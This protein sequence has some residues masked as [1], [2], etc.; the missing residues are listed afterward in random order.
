MKD[1]IKKIGSKFDNSFVKTYLVL[2]T[3]LFLI[4]IIFKIISKTPV[5]DFSTL[6]IFI[7]LNVVCSLVSFILNFFGKVV[8]RIVTIL[9][10][11][12]FGIYACLQL[13]FFNFLGVYIS[14]QTS[15]QLGA[16]TDYI[17][18]FLKTFK[19]YYLFELLPFVLLVAYYIFFDKKKVKNIKVN[20]AAVTSMIL[21]LVSSLIY[22]G[23]L[24]IKIFQ[25]KYQ[26]I[27][28]K[29]L[30]LTV[31]NP[32]V[33]IT[34]FGD[35]AFCLL[36]VR[37]M[38]FP[39]VIEEKYEVKKEDEVNVADEYKRKINDTY[40]KALNDE[41]TDETNKNLNEYFMNR[42]ITK[43]NDMTGLFKGKNLVLIMMESVNEIIYEYPELYPNFAKMAG[44]GWYFE[45]NYSPRNSC[46]T[47]NNEFSGMT[48]L[49][50]IYNTCTA[51]KW[52]SN[53]Y[54]E[55]IFGVFNDADYI[56]FSGHDYTD[57]YYPRRTIH[58]NM[59]SGDYY[60]VNRLG[61]S[62]SGEYKN[63]AD[64]ADFA[65]AMLKILD[66]KTEGNDK[67]FMM[68]MTSVS[69]HQPY[70][71]DS[72]TGNKYYSI[73]KNVK[74]LATD[75]RR[76]MSKLKYVDNMLGVMMEGL[77]ERG[78]LEDTVFVLYGDH[79]PYAISTDHLNKA[80]SYNTKSYKNNEKTPLVIYSPGI[81]SKVFSGYTTYL[82][83]VP[84]VANLFDLDYDPRYYLGDDV[85]S[86]DY[87]SLAVFADGSW[88]NETAFYSA[89]KNNI[90]YFSS[91][92]YSAEEIQAINNDIQQKIKISEKAIKNNYFNYLTNGI[93]KKKEEL[94][95][96]CLTEEKEQY[97]AEAK[98]EGENK[99]EEWC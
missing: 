63:W 95:I 92:E 17:A 14:F 57:A 34:Q 94:D 26:T 7:G 85:F 40:W 78:M 90:N 49:Y 36:D 52:K 82:N 71:V 58:P 80:L 99:N 1:F 13:G 91:D 38:L 23:T 56:T 54:G 19:W 35:L 72:I 28:N 21:L 27:S 53:K 65:K 67:N 89:S 3:G 76:Y 44:E 88:K 96:L 86:E 50:S 93:N 4:E 16:V 24:T 70:S 41:T 87:K 79:Y 64:D 39:V 9:L 37:E 31:E 77:Q 6:R 10:V 75:V 33:A 73:S 61:I 12:G 74:G 69:S 62:W 42:K 18:D 5:L 81:E 45:N 51:S 84:T 11:L 43:K 83:I 2:L 22:Y 30:F 47:M 68:W 60:G 66:K 46:A 25:N 32:S 48:S 29:N 55:S 15:S 59:G 8:K 20:K 97:E 98:S